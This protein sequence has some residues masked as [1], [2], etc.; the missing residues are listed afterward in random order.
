[1]K[2]TF[3]AAAAAAAPL[4]A[5]SAPTLAQVTISTATST[6]VATATASNG[7]PADVTI[8]SSG[9]IGLTSPGTALTLNSNNSVTNAGQLGATGQNNTTGLDIVGGF[10]GSATNSLS[11]N[12]TENSASVT[13]PNNDGLQ[14][15]P[16][17]SGSGRIGILVSPPTGG[18]APFVGSIINTGTV[19]VVGNTSEG[20]SI[21][22]PITGD[23]LSLVVTPASGSTAASIVNGAIS[24]TGQNAIG[25]QETSAGG[26]GG[27]VRLTAITA[28]GPGVQAA[29]LEGSTGGFINFSSAVV[30]TGYRA[31]S[32]NTNPFVSILYL[33]EEMQQ[34]GAAVT[35]G[36]NIGA[37][38]IVSAPPAIA[39]T[40]NL[41]QDNDGVPDSLQGT[42]AIAVL[43]SSPAIQF[44]SAASPMVIGA[45]TASHYFSPFNAAAPGQLFGFVVQGSVTAQGLFDQLTSPNLLAPI[46]ATAIQI[47]GQTLVSPL[48]YTFNS[49]H[50]VT[51]T[52][53][54]VWAPTGSVTIAG[55]LYNAGTIS[56]T[57]YQ[58][59]ATA[60][61]I[62]ADPTVVTPTPGAVVSVPTIYN[63]GQI[64]ASSIQVNSAT[65]VT[66]NGN[67]VPDTPAPSPVSVAAISIE[68]GANVTT[69]TNNSGILAEL[70]GTG[71]VGG[72]T[73][74]IV[75]RSGTLQNVNNSGSIQALLNQTLATDLLPLTSSAGASNTV[76]IDMS[77]GTLPQTISQSFLPLASSS[78]V[79]VYSTTA[80]YTVGQIVSD[81]GNLYVAAAAAGAGIDPV[82]NPTIWREIGAISPSISGDIYM[83]SGPDTLNIQAG[84][85]TAN[86]ITMGA[87]LNVITINGA[88]ATPTV[89]TGAISQRP[90]G[91]FQIS[92][93]NGQLIDTNPQLGQKATT[94]AVGPSG[95]LSIA[96]DP[97]NSRNTQFLVSG[98]TTIAAG[99]QIG[100][101]LQSLQLASVQTYTVIEGAPGSISAPAL[102]PTAI[103]NTPFLYTATA[104]L[105]PNDPQ[106]GAAEVQLTVTRK[107]AADLGFNRAETSAFNAVLADLAA[108][109]AADQG[110][111][112][113]LLAQTNAAGL[114]AVYD[115]LLPNQ[116]Q[117]IFQALDAAVERIAAFIATPPDNATHVGG[118]SM[119]LQEVNERVV[120]DGTDTL[121]SHAQAL[122]LV[123][124]YERMGAGGGAI[125][126]SLAYFN[127]QENDTA[128][129]LGARDVASIVEGG[130]YYRRSLGNLTLA[131]RGGGG[132][133]WFSENRVFASGAAL[134]E[135]QASWSGYFLD[136]HAGAAY[137][138]K[139]FG[140]YYA[141]PEV[142]ADYVRL[143]QNGYQEH[144]PNA[145]FNLAVSSQNSTQA[146]AAGLMVLGRQWGRTA[147]FRAELR[148]GYREVFAGTVGDITASFANGTPFTLVGDPD[149]GGWTT[150]GFSLKS[151][152]EFSYLALEGDADF[153]KGAHRYDL[154]VAGR[155]V[156]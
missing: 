109:A 11:I 149:K 31:T 20:V 84:T 91:E 82:N 129:Q 9:S 139:L 147:W 85:V 25:F 23:F 36:G 8:S 118:S 78:S 34:G 136:G 88:A 96:A 58:A 75:D 121:G 153:R 29:Q 17:A 77:A 154:R 74:A 35:L 12:I 120:R 115:Q 5:A 59:N 6:P 101:T 61:H 37:G 65:G 100:L 112:Q 60:I 113:A 73:T 103:G 80:T 69:I 39:S 7:A 148:G 66:V 43:G 126:L 55:G 70:T 104:S 107:G 22:D 4:L 128:A 119:W 45:Y 38:L 41:D 111:Q 106:T 131:A 124:G 40:T 144:G 156:F 135:A 95:V 49:S 152:S 68:K 44:G 97:I 56:A 143:H 3:L 86:A 16:F 146:S 46:P 50:Q 138:V 79:T 142:S 105:N 122:G 137:E 15:G 76:A 62:G 94:I 32:R 151:G 48:T 123:G 83:G 98:A 72:S 52:T 13:D 93:D 117:G 24:V 63:D 47:G 125:G 108:P 30:A 27:N 21:Q 140:P 102:G 54:P 28:T 116:G 110:I 67:G 127:V 134:D 87:G 145:A 1:M 114:R 26:I 19:T 18:V 99:G 132:Y 150:V 133:G 53:A 90:G 92:V 130:A 81:A 155:A 89:A 141:R 51:A 2:R 14:T 10:T 57:A 42:G 64:L 33:Q 71:G